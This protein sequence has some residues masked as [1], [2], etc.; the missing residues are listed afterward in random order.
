MKI[1]SIIQEIES[2]LL[3]YEYGEWNYNLWCFFL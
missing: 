1:L 3:I 2:W